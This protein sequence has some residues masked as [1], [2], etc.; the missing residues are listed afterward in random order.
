MV[1]GDPVI[2]YYSTKIIQFHPDYLNIKEDKSQGPI[3]KGSNK[4][5]YERNK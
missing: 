5:Y 2:I 4:I 3:C 1:T